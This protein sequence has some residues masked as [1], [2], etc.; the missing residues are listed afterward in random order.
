MR[1]F[2]ILLIFVCSG[3][4]L[5]YARYSWDK[6]NKLAAI[7]VIILVVLSVALP[8]LFMFFR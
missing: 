2:I 6:K 7:G 3:Y 8:V 1:Y 4:S 5:S